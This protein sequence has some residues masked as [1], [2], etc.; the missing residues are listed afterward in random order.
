MTS[1]NQI[2]D[3]IHVSVVASHLLEACSR[4]DVIAGVPFVTNIGT[5]NPTSLLTFAEKEWRKMKATGKLMP[6]SLP[7]R[8][9]QI[10]RYAP[11]LRGLTTQTSKTWEN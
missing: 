10:E 9:D 6:G 4:Q 11:D 5:G 8:T 1:G 2:S 7:N 3:F